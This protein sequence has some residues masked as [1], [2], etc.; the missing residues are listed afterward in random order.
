MTL[1]KKNIK[2]IAIALTLLLS[3]CLFTNSKNMETK[4]KWWSAWDA[5][6]YYRVQLLNGAFILPEKGEISLMGAPTPGQSWGGGSC[7]SGGDMYPVPEGLYVYWYSFT[8]DK[9]Y[10]GAFKLP[11][12]T[13]LHYFREGFNR[14]RV[15][16]HITYNNIVVGL[17]PGGVVAVWLKGDG[18]EVEIGYF[19]AKETEGIPWQKFFDSFYYRNLK[20]SAWTVYRQEMLEGDAAD[21]LER[22]GIPFGVWDTYR[23]RF[24]FRMVMVYEDPASIT[25][26]IYVEYYNGEKE[27]LSLERLAE[28]PFEKRA[29]IRYV[30]AYWS[31]G[32][33]YRKM[34]IEFNEEEVFEAYEKIYEGNP[35]TPVELQIVLDENNHY[36]YLFLVRT[37]QGNFKRVQL[38]HAKI[39]WYPAGGFDIRNSEVFKK[40]NN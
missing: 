30:N 16:K 1:Q 37:E 14:R 5:P 27:S 29:R 10:E 38:R 3:G 8:E 28:N 4:F 31:F 33:T 22:Y 9:F 13:M 6:K 32:E 34:I 40:K 20:D 18:K 17:A 19:K 23:E 21:H 35:D 39:N 11:Q 26:E 2:P 7:E 15:K 25:D 36:V 12:D 24:N